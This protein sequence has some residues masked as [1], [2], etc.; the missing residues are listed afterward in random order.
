[1]SYF[2]QVS[3]IE[4][5]NFT[6]L[7]QGRDAQIFNIEG[8]RAGFTSTSALNDLKEYDNAVALAPD[9]SNS[10]LDII[11]SSVNDTAAGTGARKVKV[12]YIDN[13][14]ALVQS[15]EI[16]LNGTTLV[17][18]V[19]TGVNHVLWVEVF[20]V[21]SGGVAAG[22][23]RLR[24]NGGVVECGQITAGGNKSLTAKFVVPVGYTGYLLRWGCSAI[25][26]DQD[27]RLRAKVDNLTRALTTVFHFQDTQYQPVNTSSTDIVLP[28]LKLPALCEVRVATISAATGAGNRADCNFLIMIVAD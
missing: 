5:V 16:S 18:S 12:T 19:L 6:G 13:S 26:T 15:G 23:I 3:P 11:S 20:E 4:S 21:G 22:N 7:Y 28:S 8:R 9:L 17:T 27:F 25:N 24:I 1:M 14:G 10:T 2:P